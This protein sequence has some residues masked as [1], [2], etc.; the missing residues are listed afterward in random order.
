ME[1]RSIGTDL[2]VHLQY[3]RFQAGGKKVAARAPELA[4]H[5][6]VPERVI[7]HSV[8]E[9]RKQG[10]AIASGDEGYWYASCPQELEHTLATLRSRAMEILRV[11]RGLRMAFRNRQMTLPLG[12]W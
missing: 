10:F 7:R 3:L 9:L 6:N 4:K 2:V 8:S 5:F 11:R 12:E 1:R